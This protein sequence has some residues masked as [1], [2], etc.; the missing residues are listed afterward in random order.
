MVLSNYRAISVPPPLYWK[1]KQEKLIYNSS[2]F[3]RQRNMRDKNRLG[4][5]T[6]IPHTWRFP[7]ML[8][9]IGNFLNNDE[10]AIGNF[11]ISKMYLSP[12]I[13][14]YYWISF[15]EHQ[16][17]NG[18]PGQC[19]LLIIVNCTIQNNVCSALDPLSSHPCLPWLFVFLSAM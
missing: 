13:V 4:L 1:K 2:L 16:F 18:Y 11:G 19:N 3:F 6:T 8:E 7:I 17:W 12:L 9:N 14:L 10:C 5:E 15:V